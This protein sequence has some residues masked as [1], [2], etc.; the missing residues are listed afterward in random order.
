LSY[1]ELQGIGWEWQSVDGCMAKTLLTQGS[2]GRNSTDLEKKGT[3]ILPKLMMLCI[4]E[5]VTFFV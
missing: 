1:D 4:A 5:P 2:V 3:K